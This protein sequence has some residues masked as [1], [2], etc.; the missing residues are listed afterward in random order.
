MSGPLAGIRVVDI[1]NVVAGPSCAAQLAD[2]GADVIKVEP[3]AG[4]LIRQS[5]ES[6]LPPMFIACN[7]GKRSLS[8]DLKRPEAADVLWRLMERADVLV[9]NLR[10]GAMERLGFGEPAVRARNPGIIYCSISGFGE[11][12][13]YA[14]KRVYDPLVQAVSGFADMQGEGIQPK[15]IRTVIADKTTAVYA[16]QAVTA[17]LFHRERTGEGQHVRL[18]MLDAMLSM[19]WAEAMG[20]FTVLADGGKVP[21]PSHDRIFET[22]D[23]HITAGAVSDSEWRGVCAALERPE[24]LTDPRY[25]T[26]ALRNRNKDQRYGDMAEVFK[27]RP[28]AHWLEALD[29][30]DVPNAPVLKRGE[31]FD[32]PQVVNNQVI[33]EFEQ[34]DV[35]MIRQARPAARFEKSPAVAPRPA[36]ILGQHSQEVLEELG[37]G[38]DEIAAMARDGIVVAR[39][40]E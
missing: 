29:K 14:G 31:V 21:P 17:A 39:E 16:A 19:M 7:R 8:I 36:P 12:G 23:G 5:S 9:Q 25:V 26:Q 38:Q 37:Y 22:E 33:H 30:N 6:G 1:T 34:P 4:D 27:T 3:P 32:H 35:G 10:P 11:T 40:S 24:W 15:M 28:S 18:A 2:Q 20:P 13:P